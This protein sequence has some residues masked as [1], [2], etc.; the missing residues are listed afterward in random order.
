MFDDQPETMD[1]AARI[2]KIPPPQTDLQ[3]FNRL[4]HYIKTGKIPWR[5]LSTSKHEVVCNRRHLSPHDVGERNGIPFPLRAHRFV[6]NHA[7]QTL[8]KER[9]LPEIG[10]AATQLL[11]KKT[12]ED[13]AAAPLSVSQTLLAMGF[14]ILSA[15]FLFHFPVKTLIFFNGVITSYF[16]LAIAY[17]VCLLSIGARLSTQVKPVKSYR[18]DGLPVMTI[19][20]PLYHDADA[21]PAL[22]NAINALDY[23]TDKKDV[24]LL[25][26]ED[27][28]QTIEAVLESNLHQHFDM[29]IVPAGKPQTKPKACNYGLQLARGDLIVIYD[30]ED[31]PE[32][33]QLR[34]AARAFDGAD[35]NLAGVQARLTYYN[36]SENWLTRLFT[37]EYSLWFD[38]LL[39]ALQKLKVPI[40][41][42]GTSNFFRTDTLK[43]IGGW[44][45]FNVTEDADLGLR[46]SKRGY[47][48]EMLNST[49]FE[50]ANCRLGNWLRQRSRWM[51]GYM[52]TWLVHMR[53]PGKIISTTGWLGFLSVQLFI[54]GNVISALVNPILWVTFLT[55]MLTKASII[56]AVFPEPLLTLNLFALTVG[57]LF[58]VLLAVIAPLKR[59]WYHLCLAGLTAPAYWLLT[60]IAAYKALW[61]MITR[62]HYWEKTDHGISKMAIAK[63]DEVLRRE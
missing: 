35:A 57:N 25:L 19:L 5:K 30:A 40:P 4:P 26:E 16:M 13:S 8:L 18:S 15:W 3:N 41:L 21:L 20:L 42:G 32:P 22:V 36:H 62:P 1:A 60:S 55:W 50:E 47:R 33:D 45:P 63:R 39:P 49:T 24:K 43:E 59:R 37:L 46:L 12:P 2:N 54:A 44:D 10:T 31:Q 29:I 28:R 9:F 27:D 11:R 51:K 38:W 53:R 6:S 52:Q 61:Q 34:K 58:F 23:P 56:S 48:V 7:F 17:R 14:L